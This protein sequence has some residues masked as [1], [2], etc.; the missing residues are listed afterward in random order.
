MEAPNP[1]QMRGRVDNTTTEFRDAY[2][3]PLALASTCIYLRPSE[4]VPGS[5]PSMFLPACSNNAK[6]P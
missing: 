2:Q 5:C 1:P 6:S 4:S 3:G